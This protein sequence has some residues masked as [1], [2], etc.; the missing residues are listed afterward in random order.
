MHSKRYESFEIFK[1][2]ITTRQFEFNVIFTIL[3]NIKRSKLK[4]LETPICAQ[5]EH[6]F[7][8]ISAYQ[9]TDKS[10]YFRFRYHDIPPYAKRRVIRC[11]VKCL[12]AYVLIKL[13]GNES[14]H[15][16]RADIGSLEISEYGLN[17]ELLAPPTKQTYCKFS[18]NGQFEGFRKFRSVVRSDNERKRSEAGCDDEVGC[19]GCDVEISIGGG[20]MGATRGFQLVSLA[21]N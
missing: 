8:S 5:R 10:I 12:C 1:S 15:N 7:A 13:G 16:G 20:F 4:Q 2:L 3:T 21:S 17:S 18:Q 11:F 14:L 9:N 6:T 19:C